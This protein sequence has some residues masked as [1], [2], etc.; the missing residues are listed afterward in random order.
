MLYN[1]VAW[2]KENPF[3]GTLYNKMDGKDYYKDC[4]IDYHGDEVSKHN[5]LAILGGNESSLNLS[6]ASNSTRKVLKSNRDSKL[7][8]FFADH[9][10][11]GHIL[12]PESAM[13]AD[14][15]Y[16]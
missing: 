13:F 11:P 5:F 14:E 12:F 4:K 9:G 6:A 3:P 7:F 16:S 2:H 8:L 15:L 1:D 10:A